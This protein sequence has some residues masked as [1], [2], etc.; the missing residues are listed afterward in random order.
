MKIQHVVPYSNAIKALIIAF[1]TLLSTYKPKFLDPYREDVW[2]PKIQAAN[3]IIM[4][5]GL[6]NL[7]KGK[8]KDRNAVMDTMIPTIDDLRFDIQECINS[9]T[10]TDSLASFDLAN[11]SKS[12]LKHDIDLFHTSYEI[13]IDRINE[14]KVAL[15][16]EGFT[17]IKIDKI[18]SLHNKAISI[19]VDKS[20]LD[21]EITDLSKANQVIINACLKEDQNVLNGIK[22]MAKSMGD[23]ELAK[24]ATKTAVLK[25]I[26]ATPDKKIL[27]RKIKPASSIII[28]TNY[29]AKDIL[30]L[31]LLTDVK[32][33]LFRTMNKTDEFVSGRGLEL[34]VPWTGKVKDIPGEGKYIKL[35]NADLEILGRV[36]VNKIKVKK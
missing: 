20:D 6:Q 16:A 19:Q 34:N 36:S 27:A 14:N 11:L 21:E 30:Q 13:A 12:I 9:G 10:I 35:H 15:I 31:I 26:D 8:T 1:Y 33:Y 23:K 25:S 29:I 17:Q 3:E 2:E 22:A 32:I 28:A 7:N 24:R 5:R 18:T 4:A